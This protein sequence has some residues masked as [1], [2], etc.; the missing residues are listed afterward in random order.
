M[1]IPRRPVSPELQ[2]FIGAM[3]ELLVEA[4]ERDL[5]AGQPAAAAPRRVPADPAAGVAAARGQGREE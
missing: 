2:P 4:V 5:Q 3:A 1:K